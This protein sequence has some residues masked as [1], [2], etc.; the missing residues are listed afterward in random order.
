[1]RIVLTMLSLLALVSCGDSSP[2]PAAPS[3]TTTTPTASPTLTAAWPASAQGGSFTTPCAVS[4]SLTQSGTAVSGTV[5][6]TQPGCASLWLSVEQSTGAT[7]PTPVTGTV[8][9]GT[10]S[11][12]VVP[13]RTNNGVPNQVA[14]TFILSGT[15]TATSLTLSGQLLNVFRSWTDANG[16]SVPDCDLSSGVPNGECGAAANVALATEAFTVTASRP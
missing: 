7:F 2:S 12:R 1:M 8:D 14:R 11:L 13:R 5:T 10:V 16:N 9:G 6:S 4:M 3:P 15:F